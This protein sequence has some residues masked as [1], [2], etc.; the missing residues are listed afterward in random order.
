M[1]KILL[2]VYGIPFDD[3][4]DGEGQMGDRHL[5]FIYTAL[6]SVSAQKGSLPRNDQHD[7]VHAVCNAVTVAEAS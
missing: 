3:E 6:L 1:S 5:C 7:D 2:S 4:R